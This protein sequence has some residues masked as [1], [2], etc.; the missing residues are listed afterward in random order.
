MAKSLQRIKARWLRGENGLSIKEIAEKVGVAKSTVSLW[1]RGIDLTVSQIKRLEKRG[2]D[3]RLRGRLK[4]ARIQRERRLRRIKALQKQAKKE[5]GYLSKREL[6][7]A[8]V[9][10]YW[11]EGHKKDNQ[12]GFASSDPKMI[13]F[14]LK[15]LQK[16]CQIPKNRLKCLVGINQTHRGRIEE[17]EEYWSRLTG[18]SRSQF[19]KPSFK[20]SKTKKMY[21]NFREHYGTLLIRVSR[22]ADLQH[23]VNGWV[24]VLRGAG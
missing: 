13:L 20:K 8:G 19:T 7:I 9:A 3:G 17:V 14:F 18:I 2:E 5:I 11:A 23:Q 6:F 1:C 24:G 15:W 21:K 4:G 12:L 10:L 22:G 16:V